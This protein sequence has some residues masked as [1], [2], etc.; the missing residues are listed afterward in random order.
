MEPKDATK[1]VFT[2]TDALARLVARARDRQEGIVYRIDLKRML[3]ITTLLRPLP[4]EDRRRIP[5][6]HEL[7]EKI[8]ELFG[9]SSHRNTSQGSLHA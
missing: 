7:N 9:E 5:A 4:A 2:R 6:R 8:L 1:Q 3:P